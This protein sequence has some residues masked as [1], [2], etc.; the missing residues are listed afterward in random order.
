MCMCVCVSPWSA[1]ADWSEWVKASPRGNSSRRQNVWDPAG[2]VK[3]RTRITRPQRV[4]YHPA[5][6][7]RAEAGREEGEREKF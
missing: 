1:S 7:A 3:T 2:R 5:T 6:A 4:D